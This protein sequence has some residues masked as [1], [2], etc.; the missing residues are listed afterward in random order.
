MGSHNGRDDGQA[1]AAAAGLTGAGR[2]GTVEA[3][4]NLG[5]IL[6]G[7]TRSMVADFDNGPLLPV[8]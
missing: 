4:K 7:D 2:V 3:F 6:L 8:P 1:Q 5:R